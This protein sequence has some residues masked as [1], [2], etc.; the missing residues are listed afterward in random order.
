VEQVG[1]KSGEVVLL[2][3]GQG[4]YMEVEEE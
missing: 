4:E 3:L 1:G 2:V